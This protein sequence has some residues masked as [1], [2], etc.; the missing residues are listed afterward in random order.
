MDWTAF[1]I[2]VGAGVLI[3][4]IVFSLMLLNMADRIE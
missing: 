4:A 1:L 2:G 3:S